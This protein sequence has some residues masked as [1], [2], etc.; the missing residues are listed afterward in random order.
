MKM[1]YS[2]FFD[3]SGITR[4]GTNFWV[5]GCKIEVK[6]LFE[7]VLSVLLIGKQVIFMLVLSPLWLNSTFAKREKLFSMA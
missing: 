3:Q 4:E 5:H 1:K 6:G 7:M 2:A